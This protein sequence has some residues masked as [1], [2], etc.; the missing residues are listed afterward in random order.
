M[1]IVRYSRDSILSSLL[2]TVGYVEYQLAF[3]F[4]VPLR[5]LHQQPH[6]NATL[7][8][9]VRSRCQKNSTNPRKLGSASGNAPG[10]AQ[11]ACIGLF[12]GH[13]GTELVQLM[14][15]KK[16]TVFPPFLAPARINFITIFEPPT[17]S[18]P[19]CWNTRSI[20]QLLNLGWRHTDGLIAVGSK[21]ALQGKSCLPGQ[22]SARCSF[23][24]VDTTFGS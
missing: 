21:P 5:F 17:R 8:V 10:S 20:F 4:E 24:C 6:P 13:G 22:Q 16:L 2:G 14:S 12:F 23:S 7:V 9:N 11:E 1:V 19:H 3:A 18:Y 15:K